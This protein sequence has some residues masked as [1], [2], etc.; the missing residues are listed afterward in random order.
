MHGAGV[1]VWYGHHGNIQLHTHQSE[2]IE[3]G[4]ADDLV[5]CPSN[6]LHY[7][8]VSGSSMKSNGFG[9]GVA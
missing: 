3:K 2:M 4:L 6:T 8:M 9:F 7:Y 1:Q 5:Q